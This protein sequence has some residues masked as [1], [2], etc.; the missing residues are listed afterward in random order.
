M[1]NI[2]VGDTVPDGVFKTVLWAPELDD[3]IA[4]GIPIELK[5]EA[6][7]G[8]KVVI[9]AVPGAFTPT[10]HVNHLPPFLEKYEELKKK[11]NEIYVISGNDAFV[12]SGWA[13]SQGFKDKII[14]LSD[15]NS[16]W[17]EELGLSQDLSAMGMGKR[18]LR[19]ALI[20]DDLKVVSVEVEPGREV[21]VTGVDAV[22]SK[23]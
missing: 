16:R 13:R 4:C 15:I 7:K 6:W 21:T 1:V 23:L 19:Y 3:G 9:I 8:K 22:L 11:A 20:L 18:P 14:A 10:C 17:S 2:K 5:T 12:M